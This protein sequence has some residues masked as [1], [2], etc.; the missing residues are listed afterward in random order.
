MVR[1][2]IPGSA[3]CL[4]HWFG[5]ALLEAGVDLRTV[6]ELMR[7]QSL[8]S[9]EIYTRVTDARRAAGIDRLD[10]FGVAPV[11]EFRSAA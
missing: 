4:R 9:T 1:A 3:H 2:G 6:Q 5:T 8:T 11:P 10:P 7:H